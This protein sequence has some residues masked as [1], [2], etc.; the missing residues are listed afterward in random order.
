MVVVEDNRFYGLVT[1]EF[2]A[3]VKSRLV[4]GIM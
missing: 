4:W 1:A 3:I 2:N